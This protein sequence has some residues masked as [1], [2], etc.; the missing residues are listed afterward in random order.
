VA[1]EIYDLAHGIPNHVQQTA[2]WAFAEAGKR[3]DAAAVERAVR[4]ILGAS[5]TDF[6]ESYEKLAPAQQRLLRALAREPSHEVYSRRFLEVM[7]VAN[8]SSTRKALLRLD[9]LE[10]IELGP[11]GWRVANPFFERWLA[12]GP[13]PDA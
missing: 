12:L 5:A 9:E 6:A 7:D 1:G 3:I 13:D 2:F 4:G 10:L 11:D 8:A